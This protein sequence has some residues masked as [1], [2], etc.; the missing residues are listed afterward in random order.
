VGDEAVLSAR[1]LRRR[2]PL[3][4]LPALADG[5]SPALRRRRRQVQSDSYARALSLCDPYFFT[6]HP[7]GQAPP[8]P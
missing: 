7:H 3:A 1:A 8:Q 6:T 2:E 5:R 4:S